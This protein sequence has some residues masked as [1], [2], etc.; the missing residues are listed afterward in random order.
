MVEF[1]T[2]KIHLFECRRTH[3]DEQEE[4]G[5]KR[6]KRST[7]NQFGFFVCLDWN[8]AEERVLIWFILFSFNDPELIVLH[9]FL[10]FFV[11]TFSF[12]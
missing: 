9:V 11:F 10:S 5:T 3:E 6:L 7:P 8:P 2:Q 12:H 1:G 4:A